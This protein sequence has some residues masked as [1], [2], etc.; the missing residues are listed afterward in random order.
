LDEGEDVMVSKWKIPIVFLMIASVLLSACAS[1][2]PTAAPAAAN[3]A[4]TATTEAVSAPTATTAAASPV[5]APTA[6]ESVV[7]AP[8]RG[9]VLTVSGY[10]AP[11]S[12]DPG[13]GEPAFEGLI[14]PAYEALLKIDPPTGKLV[15]DLAVSWKWL[16]KE[17]KV[18]QMDLRP[19]V[20]FSDG[21][22]FN[23]DAVKTWLEYTKANAT[24]T[25]AN[26]GLDT[27]EVTGPLTIVLHLAQ[28]NSLLPRL[29][30][31]GW[32]AGAIACPAA[33]KDPKLVATATCGA[34]PY[35]LDA[36]NTVTG[37]TYT[38][39]P[40][41]H[42]WNP[43]AIHWNKLVFKI[44]V[45]PQSA[46]DAMKAGQIQLLGADASVIDAGVAAGMKLV[47]VELNVQGL[48]FLFRDGTAVPAIKDVRVRQALNYAIDRTALAKV[49]YQ[50]KGR[51]VS[52]E[53]LPGSEA[54]DPSLENYYP[55]DPD[56]AKALLAEA[57][58][59]DGSDNHPVTPI[60]KLRY[61]GTSCGQ[62]LGSHWGEDQN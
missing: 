24:V 41:P 44:I 34:G 27:A 51:P 7:A 49:L 32:M 9:D 37:D 6:T 10:A 2:T 8:A 53:F 62:L 12:L 19:N 14:T 22:E 29:F 11:P 21:T 61:D 43:D 48:V 5:P 36:A 4:P 1:K 31:R 33:T 42:Y 26:I 40:N 30:T 28:P 23:A 25:A 46:L 38:Y 35:M 58:Y 55:Y 59:P 54:Y 17:F 39:I 18:F 50:G 13:Q 57:G 20:L 60:L 45:N 3:P 15:P 52:S 56:K 16:D 47:G